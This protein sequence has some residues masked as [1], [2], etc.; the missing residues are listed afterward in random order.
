[1][2]LVSSVLGW[3]GGNQGNTQDT[4]EDDYESYNRAQNLLQ[5]GDLQSAIEILRVIGNN[6]FRHAQLQL[7][8]I[9]RQ[10]GEPEESLAWFER[11]A[12]ETEPCIRACWEAAR[13][14]HAG[15]ELVGNQVNYDK[16]LNYWFRVL[17]YTKFN[18][19]TVLWDENFRRLAFKNKYT[20]KTVHKIPSLIFDLEEADED[21]T[22]YVE[23][24]IKQIGSMYWEGSGLPLNRQWA[25]DLWKSIA[26]T[27]P[28]TNVVLS[29]VYFEAQNYSDALFHCEKARE[30]SATSEGEIEYYLAQIYHRGLSVT[31]NLDKAKE[32]YQEAARQGHAESK[33]QINLFQWTVKKKPRIIPPEE[34][35]NPYARAQRIGMAPTQR[36]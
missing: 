14:Y 8:E 25:L 32:Y 3:L 16:A 17:H 13:N 22:L 12:T 15:T 26:D 27:S 36:E 31:R 35:E 4:N 23:D 29:R 19:W 11:A 2:N 1:M 6:G 33:L 30:L 18:T 28:H 21:S 10:N 5:K 20:Q 7:A 9:Y 24:A 34:F